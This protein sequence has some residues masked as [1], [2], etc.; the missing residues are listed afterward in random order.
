MIHLD[1]YIDQYAGMGGFALGLK[2]AGFTFGK[3]YFS[4]IDKYASKLYM[5]M[6]PDAI[7]L[8]DIRLYRFSKRDEGLGSLYAEYL[9]LLKDDFIKGYL[10]KFTKAEA[11]AKAIAKAQREMSYARF[12]RL[13]GSWRSIP[14]RVTATTFGFPCQ[15]LSIAGKRKGLVGARS[16]LFYYSLEIIRD[17]QPDLFIFENVKGLLSSNNGRDFESVLRAIAD[18]GLYGCQWQLCNT[19]WFIPQNRERVYFVGLLRGQQHFSREV[20]PIREASKVNHLERGERQSEGERLSQTDCAV[21]TIRARTPDGSTDTLIQIGTI[22]PDSEATRVYDPAGSARTIKNGGGMG[23]K[24]GLYAVPALTPD[25]PEK[26]QNG[27]RFKEASEDMFTLTSQDK[28]GVMV[29]DLKAPVSSTRKG[30]VKEDVTP[31]LD[32]NCY[33][34]VKYGF[35]IRRL[36][37]LECFRLQGFPDWVY[38]LA[39][40]LNISDSQLYKMAGNAVSLPL[41]KTIGRRLQH[42]FKAELVEVGT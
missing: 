35:R 4:E 33:V 17:K 38:H 30:G 26:R 31:T 40:S 39:K 42:G 28:H 36:T 5:A 20:F 14:D 32:H 23:A 2:Q 25:R 27:R 6:F 9:D 8:G 29:Y 12:K 21:S 22:G 24:T 10:K 1:V 37:P 13:I 34:G 15:D 18:I 41:P 16:G 3:H 11:E 7:E 19:D